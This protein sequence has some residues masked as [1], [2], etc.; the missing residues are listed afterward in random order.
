MDSKYLK[1]PVFDGKNYG[2]WK[3]MMTHYIKGHDWECWKIVQKGPNKIMVLSSEG[4]AHEKNEDDYTEADYKKAEKNSKAMTLLQN[5]ISLTEFDRFSSCTSAKEIWDSLE[6]AYEG[7]SL[8][9]K[10][11]VDLLIQQYELFSMEKDESINS[12]STR[13]S[14]ITNELRNLGRKF[15]S[16]D[17][18]RKILRSLTEKWQPKVT[19]IE[20]AKDLSSLSYQELLGSLMAHELTLNKRASE[21]SKDKGIA[22]QAASNDIDADIEDD[23]VLFARRFRKSVFRNKQT[24]PT[25][26]K[27]STESKQSFS[28]REDDEDPDDTEVANLCLSNLSLDLFSDSEDDKG[29]KHAEMCLMGKSDSEEEDDECHEQNLELIDLKEQILEIAEENQVLKSKVKK[30]S[31][32]VTTESAITLESVKSQKA[33]LE[34]KKQHSLE[35][36]ILNKRFIDF[37]ENLLK[38]NVP[39]ESEYDHKEC[40]KEIESLKDLLRHARMVYDKWEGSTKVLNFLSQQSDNNMKMGLGHECYSRRD[41]EKCKSSPS[42]RDFRKR[43]YVDLPEYLICTYCGKTGHILDSCVK[44][45]LDLNEGIKFVRESGLIE[46]DFLKEKEREQIRNNEFRWGCNSGFIHPTNYNNLKKTQDNISSDKSSQSSRSNDKQPKSRN[47][48][49]SRSN[50]PIKK[51]IIRQIWIRKD[52]VFRVIVKESNQWYLDSGCSRHMTGDISQFLSLEPFDGGKVTFGDNKKGKVTLDDP[53]LWHKRFG[54]ISSPILEKLKRWN[55]VDGLPSIK[56]DKERLCETCARCKH[57][58]SSFKPKRIVSTNRPLE[59]VHMD[60]CGPMKVRSRGGSRYVFVLVDDYSSKFDPR[61]DEAIFIGYSNHSKAYKDEEEDEEEPDFRLS[62]DDPP[63]LSEEEKEIDGTNDEIN[64]SSNKKG[65]GVEVVVDDTIISPQ[66]KNMESEVMDDSIITPGLDSGGTTKV[67]ASGTITPEAITSEVIPENISFEEGGSS[68]TND[69]DTPFIPKKWKH[70]SSH[71]TD[72]ILGDIRKGIQTRRSLNNFCAFHSFL[73]TIEPA[74][75]KVALT[76]SDWIIAMQDE[77]HQFER[78]KVWHLVP[79]PS[80]RSVIGTRWVFRNKLDDAGVIVRNKARLVVQGYNQ[81]E[82][83]DYDETFAPVAR[84]EAIRLLIAFAAHKGLKLF[85]M[86]VKTAFLNGYLEEEVFVEQPQGF[87]NKDFQNHVFK[88][89][90]ALYGLKQAPRAWY[91]RLSKFLLQSGFQRGSVDKTLFLKSEGSIY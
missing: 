30:L 61:S 46:D 42:D 52:E 51:K 81:Q 56:F 66:N 36:H 28:N 45:K 63:E 49:T 73:S 57:V 16:E 34:S 58:R 29:H 67:I 70:Q 77:L 43:K 74:N 55:L 10:H 71:T 50:T 62:R 78:N 82:G 64:N 84:L 47:T 68:V 3:N 65:K 85:Q 20:E 1:C 26:N 39:R 83:I 22:L 25:F 14:N 2:L 21:S 12:M 11:R 76:D 37:R 69:E 6:L 41:H 35:K 59:L 88:L 13:F 15:E 23:T 79:R 60:L 17:I 31:S 33:I 89:D 32:K 54:H 90:K 8:V 87:L 38:D 18:V 53:C 5:G 24:K 72:A 91:D 27:K 48:S 86:D 44:R 9:R 7:T 80:D 4:V 19:A 75:I 40:Q